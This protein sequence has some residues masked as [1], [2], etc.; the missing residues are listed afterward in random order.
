MDQCRPVDVAVIVF[1]GSY[2]QREIVPALGHLVQRGRVRIV[3]LLLARRDLDGKIVAIELDDA[4]PEVSMLLSP[5][6]PKT[7]DVHRQISGQRIWP[8]W[9]EVCERGRPQR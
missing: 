7:D 6:T 4:S 2:I 8:T 9:R 1:E 5:L 3:D